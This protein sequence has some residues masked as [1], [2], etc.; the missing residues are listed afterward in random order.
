MDLALPEHGCVK[1]ALGTAQH[2]VATSGVSLEGKSGFRIARAWLCATGTW[3]S[4]E[5]CGYQG[6]FSSGKM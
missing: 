2:P 6:R 1:L 4:T 3:E 5:T